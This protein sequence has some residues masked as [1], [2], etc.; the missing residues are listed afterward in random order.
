MTI[1]DEDFGSRRRR[2][3]GRRGPAHAK[4]SPRWPDGATGP[5]AAQGASQPGPA[6]WRWRPAVRPP[7]SALARRS[8]TRVPGRGPTAYQADYYQSEPPGWTHPPAHQAGHPGADRHSSPNTPSGPASGSPLTP[9]GPSRPRTRPNTRAG[10]SR[11]P[12]QGGTRAGPSR[13]RTGAST[14]A[15]P[16][17]RASIPASPWPTGSTRFIPTTPAGP[18]PSSRP[19][20]ATPRPASTRRGWPAARRYRT[21]CDRHS[22]LSPI[23]R[24]APT[25]LRTRWLRSGISRCTGTWTSIRRR[26]CRTRSPT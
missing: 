11:R 6:R 20:R 17:T 4:T 15:S 13:Q 26:S 12:V 23:S 21:G 18:S 19:G 14:P 2:G 25:P 1:A 24:P 16:R 9:S 3:D 5:F 22:L 8:V 10:P 7:G